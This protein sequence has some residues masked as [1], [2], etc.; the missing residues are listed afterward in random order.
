MGTSATPKSAGDDPKVNAAVIGVGV[1]LAAGFAAP[2][3]AGVALS[4][5][6]FSSSGIVAGSLAASWS[7]SGGSFF[8]VLQSAAEGGLGGAVAA[9]LG[10]A[11]GTAAAVV[12]F[13]IRGS[14]P[15][16][17]S[18]EPAD[19][20]DDHAVAV[21][22]PADKSEPVNEIKEE[23]VE[24]VLTAKKAVSSEV[25]AFHKK[26]EDVNVKAPEKEPTEPTSVDEQLACAVEEQ[27][28]SATIL[29]SQASQSNK[30][31]AVEESVDQDVTPAPAVIQDAVAK[32]VQDVVVEAVVK[33]ASAFQPEKG[34]MDEA[35]TEKSEITPDVVPE[36]VIPAAPSQHVDEPSSP[37]VV[38]QPSDNDVVHHASKPEE[39]ADMLKEAVEQLVETEAVSE[40]VPAIEEC[41]DQRVD[42]GRLVSEDIEILTT[43]GISSPVINNS[44]TTSLFQELTED[45]IQAAQEPAT[46]IVFDVVEKIEQEE[47]AQEVIAPVQTEEVVPSAGIVEEVATDTFV[48]E[49]EPST[50]TEDAV[51][52]IHHVADQIINEIESVLSASISFL[53]ETEAKFNQEPEPGVAKDVEP[54]PSNETEK[55]EQVK[56]AEEE[57]P[58]SNETQ[59]K[60]EVSAKIASQ[61]VDEESEESD[62]AYEE[63]S[64]E[65]DDEDEGD[66]DK[67]AVSE[68]QSLTTSAQSPAVESLNQQQQP[69]PIKPALVQQEVLNSTVVELANGQ[70]TTAGADGAGEELAEFSWDTNDD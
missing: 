56:P 3:L 57:K 32:A 51:N 55:P 20:T 64:A 50:I 52:V 45:D 29:P 30:P 46:E 5:A 36:P 26:L 35:N 33:L 14:K 15:S 13:F 21:P 27:I 66:E 41:L 28:L 61:Q 48:K 34:E 63:E 18:S 62:E 37:A 1:G 23:I 53:Q 58:K 6:G 59:D 17:P 42:D 39:E 4:A 47:T 40:E 24:T 16:Q 22:K 65:S 54:T 9:G 43:S 8:R 70:A 11:L 67:D 31:A 25:D 49:A 12:S 10:A 60:V 68:K 38:Q 19:K 2:L 69:S 44:I 7:E